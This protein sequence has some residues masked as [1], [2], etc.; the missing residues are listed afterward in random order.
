MYLGSDPKSV[1][2]LAKNI[3]LHLGTYTKC[4]CG[5]YDKYLCHHGM[6]RP[7]VL[8]GGTASCIKGSCEYMEKVFADGKQ[9]LLN[10]FLTVH[11]EL[12]MH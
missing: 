4:V 3:F 2:G 10:V 12:T 11:L 1:L 5:C 9:G 6:A 8:D 7:R